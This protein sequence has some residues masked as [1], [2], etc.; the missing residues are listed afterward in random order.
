[1]RLLLQIAIALL[2]PFFLILSNVRI[3]MSSAYARWEYAK[4]NFPSPEEVASWGNSGAR[5][6]DITIVP[7]GFRQ[8]IVD[9]T[10]DY[11]KGTGTESLIDEDLLFDNGRRVYN[12]REV[13]HLTDVRILTGQAFLTQAIIG[14]VILLSAVYLAR[15]GRGS[16]AAKALLTGSIFTVGLIGFIGVFAAFAFRFYFVRFHR[17]F[18][19]GETWMFPNT[20]TLIQIFPEKFWFD[21]SLLIVLFTL[22]SAVIIGVVSIVWIGMGRRANYQPAYSQ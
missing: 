2:L 22:V 6:D 15:T 16:S 14:I 20:D 8:H 10:L 7:I 5:S 21:V 17:M 13:K 4:P 12:E 18:F 3:F 19:E 9:T 1:M 11:V